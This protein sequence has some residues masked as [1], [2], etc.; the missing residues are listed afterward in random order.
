ML[1]GEVAI[2]RL[3]DTDVS[4]RV[5]AECPGVKWKDGFATLGRFDLVDVVEAD[6]PKEVEKA[7]MMI[8][9]HGRSTTKTLLATP[10][11]GVPGGALE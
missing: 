5:K 2:G 6:N 3:T 9:A 1:T 11:S 7:A 8:R 10:L 4:G